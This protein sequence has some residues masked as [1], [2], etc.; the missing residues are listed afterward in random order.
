M[1]FTLA[2]VS[3][4]VLVIII[5]AVINCAI[6][7]TVCVFV[8]V[9]AAAATE[10]FHDIVFDCLHVLRATAT[11]PVW[12]CRWCLL[13]RDP[14][15]EQGGFWFMVHNQPGHVF[16]VTSSARPRHV[17]VTSS[18]NPRHVQHWNMASTK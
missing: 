17:L 15:L 4:Q 3:L 7:I 9:I 11:G 8:V 6:V 1:N 14:D 13:A 18:S 16:P 12:A 10:A 5:I 2:D